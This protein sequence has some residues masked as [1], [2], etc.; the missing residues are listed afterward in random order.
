MNDNIGKVY[1]EAKFILDNPNTSD[2]IVLSVIVFILSS[3]SLITLLYFLTKEK[4]N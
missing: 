3:F 1:K 4:S 2:N